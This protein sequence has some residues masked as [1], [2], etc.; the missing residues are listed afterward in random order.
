L[1][2]ENVIPDRSAAHVNVEV[3]VTASDTHQTVSAAEAKQTLTDTV[4]ALNFTCHRYAQLWRTLQIV[5][6]SVHNECT[7]A[8]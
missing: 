1:A 5:C 2:L 8:K 6:L 4:A 3:R 7:V